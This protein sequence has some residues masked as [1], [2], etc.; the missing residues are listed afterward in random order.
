MET[1]IARPLLRSLLLSYLLSAALLAALAFALY[2]LRL[3]EGQVNTLVYGIYFAACLLG[4]LAAGKR[5]RTRRFF[6]GFLAGL[7]YFLV[8]FAVSWAMNM[9]AAIDWNRSLTVLG[10]CVLGGTI[11][12]MIS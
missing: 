5:L 3:K 12:G 4:G 7:A 2:R 11:G 6:W 10:A 9:G 8:L 1:K